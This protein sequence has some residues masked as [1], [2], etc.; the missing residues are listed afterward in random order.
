M[1][2]FEVII[3]RNSLGLGFSI[4]G[5]PEA[6]PPFKNMIRI[7]KV[8]PLQPAWETGKIK[9]GDLLHS[10]DGTALES[11]TLRQ[12]LDVLRSSSKATKLIMSRAPTTHL[13][14]LFLHPETSTPNRDGV[15]KAEVTVTTI[16]IALLH[17]HLEVRSR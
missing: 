11:M 9:A 13:E 14:D 16:V 3:N 5:G 15:R 2:K 12:A 1:D 17:L 4:M 7:K 6:P 8:F 10:V